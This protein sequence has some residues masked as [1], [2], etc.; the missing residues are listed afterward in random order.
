MWNS[1]R[2]CIQLRTLASM[3]NHDRIEFHVIL[4]IDL[5]KHFQKKRTNQNIEHETNVLLVFAFTLILRSLFIIIIFILEKSFHHTNQNWISFALNKTFFVFIP[6]VYYAEKAIIHNMT[7]IQIKK[8][9]ARNKIEIG[10]LKRL[11]IVVKRGKLAKEMWKKIAYKCKTEWSGT[12]THP[13]RVK[14]KY[15]CNKSE[16]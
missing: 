5:V 7:I 4:A 12:H 11:G 16:H 8:K 13:G 6:N 2:A 15:I 10:T 14:K 1:M 3:F 9:C